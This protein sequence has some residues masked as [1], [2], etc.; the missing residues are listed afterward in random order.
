MVNVTTSI[1]IEPSG[2]TSGRAD[3]ASI[4]S[5][6]ESFRRSKTIGTITLSGEYS[7]N[8]PLVVGDP[9]DDTVL[10]CN[11]H[12]IG[13]AIISYRGPRTS[14]YLLRMHGI[15]VRWNDCVP[16]QR[17]TQV[18]LRCHGNCRGL[19]LHNQYY[20]QECSNL[21]VNQSIEVGLDV[22]G[23][24]VS[25]LRNIHVQQAFGCGVRIFGS[26]NATVDNL[27]IANCVAARQA[28]GASREMLKYECVHGRDATVAKY[29]TDYMEAWPDANDESVR[30]GASPNGTPRYAQTDAELR[31]PLYLDA[32]SITIRNLTL[33]GN[34]TGSR[35]LICIKQD[36]YSCTFDRVYL[37]DNITGNCKVLLRAKADNDSRMH[38]IKFHDVTC[39]DYSVTC[40]T[41]VRT[42]GVTSDVHID[43][44]RYHYLTDSIITCDGGR[45]YGRNLRA[46]RGGWKQHLQTPAIP[47]SQWSKAINGG[48]LMDGTPYG[49]NCEDVDSN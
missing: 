29:G 45:H 47:P 13:R 30:R 22:V 11:I 21:Q 28:T 40:P 32:S 3:Y 48:T 42:N 35:P 19:L 1:H 25:S 41:F 2:D 20:F 37:E 38:L 26:A 27:R 8:A 12:G 9:T 34:E 17:L 46:I 14:S 44:L 39:E 33:E 7:V 36:N 18:A 23:S 4:S 24:H 10:P 16:H 5:A 49:H 6:I 43:G 15:P 31:C